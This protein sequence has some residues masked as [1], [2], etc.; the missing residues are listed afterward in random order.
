MTDVS[1]RNFRKKAAPVIAGGGLVGVLG[2]V[3]VDRTLGATQP[4]PPS[5]GTIIATASYVISHQKIFYAQN[6]NT[7]QI[8]YSGTDA[9]T[10]IQSAVNALA[11]G[12][13]VFIRRGIYLLTGSVVLTQHIHLLRHHLALLKSE[14]E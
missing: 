13:L 9:T 6:G 1:R 11:D 5:Q 4:P 8:D 3:G 12:A 10:V 14:H 2:T 7:G